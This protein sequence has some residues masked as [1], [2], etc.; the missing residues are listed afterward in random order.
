MVKNRFSVGA[1]V[2][3]FNRPDNRAH[4]KLYGN[5]DIVKNLFITGGADDILNRDSK[6]PDP[7]PRIRDQVPRR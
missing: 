5:Y 7:L 4:L 2:F 3:D 6:V 1:D